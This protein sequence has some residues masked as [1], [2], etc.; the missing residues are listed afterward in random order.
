MTDRTSNTRTQ[1]CYVALELSRRTWL[2]G[3][4]LPD[5]P[6]VRTMAVPGGDTSALLACLEQMRAR[7][8]QACD[9][10][11]NLRVC[12]EAGYDGFWIARFLIDQGIDTIVLD[13]TSFLVSRRGRRVKTDRV[14]VEAMCNTLKAFL[15]GDKSVCRPVVLPT[16]EEEDS[17]RIC[18]ERTQL[19]KE[20]TRHVNRI[21][22]LLN[23]HGIRDFAGLQTGVLKNRLTDLR[24]GDGRSLGPHIRRELTRQMERL[25][26]VNR[27][28]KALEVERGEAVADA[29]IPQSRK[30]E[31]LTRLRGIG[32]IGASTM[33]TE[34]F[35]RKFQNRKHLAS[36][37]GLSPA[38]YASGDRSRDQGISKAGNKAARVMMVELAWC[39]LR[40]QPNSALTQWYRKRF[41][42]DAATS[43]K[44]GVIALA[45][46][47]AIALWRYLEHGLVPEGAVIKTS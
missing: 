33:V 6:K 1:D 41:C 37:L 40:Y 5:S 17:R 43:K 8:V 19:T 2:V 15:L 44:V 9:C 14:D 28:I 26:L 25:E 36:Y 35:Q 30:V 38:H 47:L 4:I 27:Q 21:K 31:M 29:E 22:A 20:R 45:R 46:K 7:A 34:V 39:W 11:A 10:D 13:A 16:P 3:A 32:E 24:T 23:L 12:F 18:R 42:T